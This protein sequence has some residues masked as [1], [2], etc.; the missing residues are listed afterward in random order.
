[1][2]LTDIKKELKKLDKNKLIELFAE[3]YKKNNSVKEFLNFYV[4]PD[5]K[6]LLEK[7]RNKVFEAFYPK[8]GNQLMLKVGKQAI[9]D[10]KKLG[11]SPELLADLMLFYVE[12]GVCFTNDFGD[13]DQTF[14]SSLE[15]TF[16]TA[17]K[18]MKKENLLEKFVDRAGQ[19]V[20]DSDG[21]G[22]GFHY[23]L[24]EAYTDFFSD[25][26]EDEPVEKIEKN[27]QET[28]GKIIKMGR[29]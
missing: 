17:L 28:G 27:I 2:G 23:Y 13:I 22:W 16:H 21:I 8:R 14:Y 9:N 10:F 29:P 15:N 24:L 4:N 1:M 25:F 3:L 26:Y 7:Y 12:T 6:E 20:S 18:L 5:E 19:V 11:V